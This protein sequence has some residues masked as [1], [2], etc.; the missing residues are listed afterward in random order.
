MLPLPR[1]DEPI[2][3][4][5]HR[6]A[7]AA[8]SASSASPG[9]ALAPLVERA[10]RPRARA[11]PRDPRAVP[12]PPR[13]ADRP[14]PGDP[15]P[16]AAFVHRRGRARAAG[17]RRPGRAAA[18]ARA[19]PGGRAPRATMQRRAAPAAPAPRPARRVHR[20]RLPQRQARP[21]AGRGGGRPD[22]CEHRGGGALGGA[23]AR[24]RVLA[25]DRRRSPQTLVELRLL[26]EATLDFP[27]EEIDFL[28]RADARG[29]LAERER[30]AS[31]RCWR[32]A[33]QGALLREGI[34]VV[35]AGQPNV[36]KSSLLNALAGAELAIV[37]DD[38]RHHARQGR[39]RRSR[40]KA[41]R[42]TSI[43]TAGLREAGDEVERDR[44][45]AHLG[46][47]SAS[48][49]AVRVPARPDAARR[50]GY[51]A[52]DAAHR[53]AAAGRRLP[54]ARV[55][56]GLQQGRCRAAA[57]RGARTEALVVSALTGAGLDGL[58]ARAARARRLAGRAARAS[59]SPAPATSTRCNAPAPHLDARRRRMPSA[60][61]RRSSS[62]PKSCAL[63]H[64]ALGEITGAFTA[65]DLLGAIFGRFCI[66]K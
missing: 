27:E 23:L 59:S 62:S 56:R 52:G 39:R 49:D 55:A 37:T 57:R 4:D 13:R 8:R 17:A 25:R 14:R 48:A 1:H 10:L 21:G 54:P 66:G 38:P 50:A 46:R 31:T 65:D 64:D 26:V 6:A 58:R 53:R 24:R 47:R 5:R 43:D 11:A 41:C 30:A 29:R 19:L 9:A 15:L 2:V 33:R 28:E 42:S 63:A 60:A 20:A 12:R 36:G 35:L 18:A 32:R 44:R 3:A 16:G 45:R 61:T 34:R 22:R 7:G 51:D 40:S